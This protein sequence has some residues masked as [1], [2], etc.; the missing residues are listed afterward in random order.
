MDA[1][2]SGVAAAILIAI[3]AAAILNGLELSSDAVFQAPGNVRL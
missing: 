2:L 3:A 1:I